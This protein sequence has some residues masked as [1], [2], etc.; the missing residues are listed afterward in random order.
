MIA[1]DGGVI[2]L[3]RRGLAAGIISEA[4]M[5]ILCPDYHGLDDLCEKRTGR[6]APGTGHLFALDQGK[7]FINRDNSIYSWDGRREKMEGSNKQVTASLLLQ[8][9]Q[10]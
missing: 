7:V 4:T 5:D 6:P 9:S 3:H 10:K 8:W 1:V 2:A